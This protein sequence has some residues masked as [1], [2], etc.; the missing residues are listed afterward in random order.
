MNVIELDDL[1]LD[2]ILGG[3]KMGLNHPGL[4]KHPDQLELLKRTI[5]HIER[6]VTLR[7]RGNE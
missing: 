2:L 1:E 7:G 6:Q 4:K 3:M 5:L